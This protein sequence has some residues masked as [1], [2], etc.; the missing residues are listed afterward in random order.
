MCFILPCLLSVK[1][2]L[3][4][5]G[6]TAA[7]VTDLQAI[8]NIETC[9]RFKEVLLFIIQTDGFSL[10]KGWLFLT[11]AWRTT[12]QVSCHG[13]E[14]LC[15]A[16]SLSSRAAIRFCF[17]ASEKRWKQQKH[18]LYKSNVLILSPSATICNFLKKDIWLL[19]LVPSLLNT[20]ALGCR[21]TQVPIEK[22]RLN[23]QLSFSINL[24]IVAWIWVM[25][26]V[27]G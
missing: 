13:R 2:C 6:L 15:L 25:I 26:C 14:A 20:D 21:Q 12:L 10:R 24:Q 5:W 23:N 7:S 17:S 3:I 19:S 8:Y 1:F 16:W 9:D 18:K 27:Q 11:M 4:S 22:T